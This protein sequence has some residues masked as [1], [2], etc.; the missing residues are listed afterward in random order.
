MF[1]GKGRN[2][3][4]ETMIKNAVIGWRQDNNVIKLHHIIKINETAERV[5]LH[6]EWINKMCIYLFIVK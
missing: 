3:D 6:N 5:K 4:I 1:T 2:I